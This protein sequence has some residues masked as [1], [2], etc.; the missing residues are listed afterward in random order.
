MRFR[1]LLLRFLP[2]DPALAD[3][4]YR[5]RAAAK[6]VY[7]NRRLPRSAGSAACLY[8]C[9]S[10]RTSNILIS[11]CLTCRSHRRSRIMIPPRVSISAPQERVTIWAKGRSSMRSALESTATFPEPPMFVV[12]M[13]AAMADS[14]G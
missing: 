2:E 10:L 5:D 8:L 12:H 9:I 1:I 4:H 7:R 6:P 3:R 13:P 11:A 14:S